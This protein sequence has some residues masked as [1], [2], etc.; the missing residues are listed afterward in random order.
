MPHGSH[1]LRSGSHGG[2]FQQM[3]SR[4]PNGFQPKMLMRRSG[5]TKTVLRMPSGILTASDM[6]LPM[7]IEIGS[8]LSQ[9]SIGSVVTLRQCGSSRPEM[10]HTHFWN[11]PPA[12]Q[13]T[14]RRSA[15]NTSLWMAN[16]RSVT[17]L[18][19]LEGHGMSHLRVRN[20]DGEHIIQARCSS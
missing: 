9:R 15:W 20:T 2:R 4:S 18:R 17:V 3:G 10:A 8:P 14:A 11:P 12:R 6:I 1:V 19:M 13:V 5:L 16:T 7:I